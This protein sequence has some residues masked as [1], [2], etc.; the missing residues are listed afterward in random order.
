M[1]SQYDFSRAERGKFFKAGAKLQ[2]PVYLDDDV[3]NYLS[4]RAQAKG[5]DVS[6]LVNQLL[7]QDIAMIEAIK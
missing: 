5:T 2:L 6:H 4:D 7:K 3:M 1:K